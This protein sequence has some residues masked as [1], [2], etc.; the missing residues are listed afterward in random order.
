MACQPVRAAVWIGDNGEHNVIT[1]FIR[2]ERL[3]HP[4]S[5]YSRVGVI[6]CR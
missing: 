1:R 5:G 2:E 6:V 4:G 3:I